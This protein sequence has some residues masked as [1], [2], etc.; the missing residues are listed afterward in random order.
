M[1]QSSYV[2]FGVGVARS[3]SRAYGNG[4]ECHRCVLGV[5]T[6]PSG[7]VWVLAVG[8]THQ[9]AA[10]HVHLDAVAALLDPDRVPPA[11]RE[12]RM[13]RGS[14]EALV[15]G[16]ARVG[17]A[18]FP[19]VRLQDDVVETLVAGVVPEN[20]ADLPGVG[21]RHAQLAVGAEPDLGDEIRPGVAREH[22]RSVRLGSGGGPG[23]LDSNESDSASH[24]GPS[25]AEA[26]VGKAPRAAGSER[27]RRCGGAADEQ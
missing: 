12:D 17:L 22:E 3:G 23:R 1:A 5:Q 21:M 18:E 6:H 20:P 11:W 7:P 14:E 4:L 16:I 27:G 26:V 24:A 19:A 9:A 25:V 2:S 8:K 15:T 10:V 13:S